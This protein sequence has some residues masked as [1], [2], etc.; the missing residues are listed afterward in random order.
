MVRVKICGITNEVDA[1][2]AVDAGADALGF[3]LYPK[4]PRYIEPEK[5]WDFACDLPPYV[6]R[7][8]VTVNLDA[9]D[10]LNIEQNAFFDAWQLHGEEPPEVCEALDPRC[11]I[12]AL[13]LP[14]TKHHADVEEYLV[15]AFL[16]DTPSKNFGG[17]GKTF[18]W[19][20][21]LEFKKRYALPLVLSGGM[22]LKNVE[23][24][25]RVVQPYAIDVSSGVELKP[26]KKDHAKLKDFIQLC[27]SIRTDS[28]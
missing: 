27:K 26:G 20:L 13:H 19:N 25:I 24:A 15:N 16:L 18:D 21:A 1:L 10:I 23:E 3:I 6:Q 28:V 12:K 11:L 9:E 2:A 14:L 5:A 17:T 8:A 22:N 7:V 4:S